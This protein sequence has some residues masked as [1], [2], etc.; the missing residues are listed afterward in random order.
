[1][2][3]E[4]LI[5]GCKAG[6]RKCQ[7]LLVRKYA[8]VLMAICYRYT[9]DKATAQDALQETFINVFKYLNS[10]KGNG[11]FD[12]WIKR[13]AVN[14]SLSFI[15]KLR[16]AYYADEIDERLHSKSLVPDVYSTL[17]RESILELLHELPHSM[18]TIFNLCVIEGY[19]HR[20]V[21][22]M[23]GISERTSRATLSRSRARLIDI[24]NRENALEQKRIN[25]VHS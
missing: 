11:S 13:I 5:K 23:L 8:N 1:M 19:N 14:C 9:K 2:G 17:N 20:D 12:G 6:D 15:K 21:S 4:Q 16:A 18:Y 22:E 25:S 10:Y 3:I 24:M 7:D